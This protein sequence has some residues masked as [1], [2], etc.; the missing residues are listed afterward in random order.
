MRK[1]NFVEIEELRWDS[2]PIVLNR[3]LMRQIT[4]RLPTEPEKERVLYET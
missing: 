4:Q 1:L 2:A 3:I